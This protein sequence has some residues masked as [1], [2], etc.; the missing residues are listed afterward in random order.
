MR[1]GKRWARTFVAVCRILTRNHS[2]RL[3]DGQEVF[4]R[5]SIPSNFNGFA[6]ERLLKC[7]TVLLIHRISTVRSGFDLDPRTGRMIIIEKRRI[8]VKC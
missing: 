7:M 1:M 5:F 3:V 6:V 2:F 4:R 8:K